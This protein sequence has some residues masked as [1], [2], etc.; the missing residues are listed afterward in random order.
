MQAAPTLG[1]TLPR[2]DSAMP[3]K[4]KDIPY[5]DGDVAL[6]GYCAW[7]DTNDAARPG[8]LV[9]HEWMGITDHERNAC[10]RLAQAGYLAFAPD[11]F[12]RDLR[13]RNIEEAATL[14]TR[15]RSGERSELRQRAKLGMEVLRGQARVRTGQMAALGF[16]FGGATALEL[17][18]SGAPLSAVISFHGNLATPRPDD[19]KRIRARVLALHGAEDPIV[20][21]AEVQGFEDEMRAARLDWELIKFGGA[22]HSYT[23]PGAGN[24]PSRGFAYHPVATAR[25]WEAALAWLKESFSQDRQT[26]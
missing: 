2:Q 25:S 16:C 7:D 18:R 1:N 20:P 24:D 19:A 26:T 9:F 23:N 13:P 14:A 15:Y 17:A 6:L 5:S 21:A 22:V 11:I 8:V 10:E 3:V 4:N 12:G